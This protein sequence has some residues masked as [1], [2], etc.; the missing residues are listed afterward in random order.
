MFDQRIKEA[1]TV[2]VKLHK[3]DGTTYWKFAYTCTR[4]GCNN[5]LEECW[6]FTTEEAMIEAKKIELYCSTGCWTMGEPEKFAKS[7]IEFK[8]YME[9]YESEGYEEI[10][11]NDMDTWLFWWEEW[12][13]EE[14]DG[15][16]VA[17][18]IGS[19]MECPIWG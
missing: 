16:E 3:K 15:D 4:K 13:G 18:M 9:N 12:L 19:D 7:I 2:G 8:E 11:W 1:A 14:F 10:N 17:D 6:C 5:I